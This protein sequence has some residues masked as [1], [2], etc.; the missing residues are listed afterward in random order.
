MSNPDN[1]PLFSRGTYTQPG[2]SFPEVGASSAPLTSAAFFIGAFCKEYNEDFMLCKAENADPR[3]CLKE[4]RKVTRCT[5]DLLAKLK[6]NCGEQFKAHWTCLDNKNHELNR[7]RAEERAFNQCVF[8][9]LGLSKHI[10]DTPK[11]EEPI[12]LKSRPIFDY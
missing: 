4:G 3:H 1:T 10:P 8:D 2:A 5:I 12:H 11:G 6:A 9:K 7:C